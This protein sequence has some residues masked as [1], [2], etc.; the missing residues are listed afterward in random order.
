MRLVVSKRSGKTFA[1]KMLQ[2]AQIVALNQTKNI[3]NEKLI[4]MTL[5]HPFVL[6]LFDT[7]KDPNRLYML[8][9]LV[10]GGELFSRLQTS[11]TPGRVSVGDARFYGACVLDAFDHMHLQNIIYRDLK[12]E[13]L[14]IDCEGYIRVVDFGFAKIVKNRT[15]T[16]CGTPEY[17]APEL[18]VGKGHNKGVDYWALGVLLYEMVGGYSPFADHERG[19]QMVICKNI[20]RG[21]VRFPSVINNSDLKEVIMRLLDKDI[22]KRLGMLKGGAKD[23]KA[24]RFF[25][26]INWTRMLAKREKAP[27]TPPISDPLDTSNFD[28]YDED[29]HVQPY[30][31]DGTHWDKHF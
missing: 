27:W 5:D 13:N 17:L 8:L 11:A 2:K 26:K 20:L 15:Y 12:P 30:R 22:T 23:I 24:H 1:L 3:M 25:R 18:L 6:R 14:L 19:D 31:D 9:E 21:H 29:D 7:F 28:P 10:Q 4:L 16:L